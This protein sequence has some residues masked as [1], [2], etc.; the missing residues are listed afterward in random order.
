M[1]KKYQCIKCSKSVYNNQNAILCIKCLR[2]IH[3]KCS[4]VDISFFQSDADW[5]CDTCLFNEL[6][7]LS[8][9]HVDILTFD[10]NDDVNHITVNASPRKLKLDRKVFTIAHLNV[11]SIR[12]KLDH[13]KDL[14]FNNPFDILGLS[15]TWLDQSILDPELHLCGYNLERK[16]RNSL[17]GG[18][19]CYINSNLIYTRKHDL[20]LEDL[21]ILWLEVKLKHSQLYLIAVVYRPPNSSND[22][23]PKV[24]LQ[25]EKALQY[26]SNVVILGDFNCNMLTENSLSLKMKN[27][28]TYLQLNQ[29]IN[30]PTRIT[31]NSKTCIDLILLPLE[32]NIFQFDVVSLGLSDHSLIYV[33][34]K[35]KKVPVAPTIKQF[36]SFR[37]FNRDAFMEEGGHINWHDVYSVDNIDEKW[38]VFKSF[39][40]KLCDK[41]A[42]YISVRQ[43]HKRSPWLTDEYLSLSRE[44]D[45]LKERFDGKHGVEDKDDISIWKRYQVVRNKVN[46]WNKKL[47]KD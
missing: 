3:L 34:T 45:Y 10:D 39:F 44:R 29:I 16:D 4:S 40:V 28:C 13:L 6:P 1:G 9:D 11:R 37:N 30:E 17:G 31:N 7:F 5:I 20:E 46:N 43:R 2:W 25:F 18:V 42:P 26:T 8:E 14:L 21:E 38:N 41:H 23:F 33:D 24:E 19:A 36:R 12:G 32:K 22:F 35:V 27:M 47:K 15:E